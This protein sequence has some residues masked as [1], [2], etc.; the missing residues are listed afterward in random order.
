MSKR[1]N[2]NNA[3]G[4]NRKKGQPAAKVEPESTKDII[5]DI[6]KNPF[7]YKRDSKNL[8]KILGGICIFLAVCLLFYITG[9][10]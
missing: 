8:G 10:M 4:I 3:V 9:H 5:M 6:I 7:E 2:K 1:K